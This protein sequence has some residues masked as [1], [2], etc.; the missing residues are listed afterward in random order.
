MKVVSEEENLHEAIK[1]ANLSARR[2]AFRKNLPYAILKDGNVI[3][4]YPDKHTEIATPERLEQL[5]LTE[6]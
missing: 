6:A 2:K 1:G 4:V 3:L 5:H